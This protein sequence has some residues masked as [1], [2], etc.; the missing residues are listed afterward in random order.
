[1]SGVYNARSGAPL[2]RLRPTGSEDR[3]QVL[4]WPLWKE[5]WV[6]A[7]PLGPAKLS[8]KRALLFIPA[9]AIFWTRR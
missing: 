2:A 9:E 5:R 1:M 6:S 4:Y 7:E 3:F 8:I